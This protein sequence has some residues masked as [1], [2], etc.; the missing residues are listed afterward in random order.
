V[1]NKERKNF[2]YYWIQFYIII[3]RLFY[4]FGGLILIN[5]A[6]LLYH[7]ISV[8]EKKECP[9]FSIGEK[10][11]GIMLK[12]KSLECFPNYSKEFEKC[13]IV[14]NYDKEIIKIGEYLEGKKCVH[15]VN[16]LMTAPLDPENYKK[17]DIKDVQLTKISDF[18]DKTLKKANKY[19]LSL[20]L[21]TH[22]LMKNMLKFNKYFDQFGSEYQLKAPNTGFLA[23]AYA[24][25]LLRPKTLWV[26]GLDFYQSDYLVRRP[27]QSP[28]DIQ[29]Q[30]MDR[31]NLVEIT[32]D[33]FQQYPETQI[34]FVTYYEGFPNLPNVK[35]FKS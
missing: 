8:K 22:F 16:R 30:K 27:H 4:F 32:A 23:I 15:F 31:I 14:N 33:L 2:R 34:N 35:I 12:G 7:K 24:L 17:Y 13:F 1:N 29:R 9:Y 5:K 6:I 26:I 3:K 20:D 28:I 18:G 10:S 19:Y 21:E 25:E 11:F